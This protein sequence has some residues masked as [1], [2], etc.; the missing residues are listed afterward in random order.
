LRSYTRD[1]KTFARWLNG[2][3]LCGPLVIEL[4]DRKPKVRKTWVRNDQVAKILEAVTPKIGPHS[5]PAGKVQARQTADELRFILYC[6]FHAGL[7]RKEIGVARVSWFD[8]KA[9]LLHLSN[10]QEFTS[11]DTENRTVPLTKEFH[12]FVKV[13]LKGRKPEEFCLKPDH[14]AGRAKYRYEALRLPGTPFWQHQP[15]SGLSSEAPSLWSD[16][17]ES[18]LGVVP[19]SSRHWLQ[20]G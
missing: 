18:E 19:C 14:L 16:G 12:E 4:P 7:R 20:T 5:K 9:G 2:R 11:K 3:G 15:V 17:K 8:L 1:I 13:F 6:G 10:D